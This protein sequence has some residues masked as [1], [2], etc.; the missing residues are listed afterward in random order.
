MKPREFHLSTVG[1][2]AI[3]QWYFYTVYPVEFSLQ[4]LACPGPP[5]PPE[6]SCSPSLPCVLHHLLQATALNATYNVDNFKLCISS[7]TSALSSRIINSTAHLTPLLWTS[8]GHLRL[9]YPKSK[10]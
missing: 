4:V 7:L 8:N 5:H 3:G 2:T 10:S 6:L 9:K 1:I